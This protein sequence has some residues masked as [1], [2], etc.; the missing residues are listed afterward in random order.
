M[1]AQRNQVVPP[2]GQR[3]ALPT[4]GNRHRDDIAGRVSSGGKKQISGME[5][6]RPCQQHWRRGS[7][8]YGIKSP[9]LA[10][11]RLPDVAIPHAPHPAKES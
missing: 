10:R 6:S 1:D 9:P 11:R 5:F 8:R 4:D 7:D 2:V 3:R